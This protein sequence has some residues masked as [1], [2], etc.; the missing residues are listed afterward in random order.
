MVHTLKGSP[1]AM[2]KL[3]PCDHEAMGNSPGKQ[4]L[5]EMH[6]KA[7]YTRPKVVG[8]CTGLPFFHGS[9]TSTAVLASYSE[10][11]EEVARV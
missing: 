5:A 2:V 1:D 6:G 3:L 8:P 4:P 11:G 9:Y 7:E 10:P